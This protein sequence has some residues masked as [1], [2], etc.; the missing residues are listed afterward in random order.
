[1][2]DAVGNITR[3]AKQTTTIAWTPYGKVDKVT[4]DD[5]AF[6]KFLY[7]A[8]GNR[9]I[10]KRVNTAGLETISYYVRDPSG[11]I[12]AVYERVNSTGVTGEA[13]L[14][15]IPIY[16]SQRLGAYRK[17]VPLGA[18]GASNGLFNRELSVRQYELNDHLGNVRN[19]VS[20]RKLST[21]SGTT[22]SNF[23]PEVV[24][25]SQLLSVWYGSPWTYL[26]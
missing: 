24:T 21:L 4:K 10:K 25:V 19:V 3:D 5:A 11:N 20:D 13:V 7:D 22:F 23:E 15:E 1:L 26:E 9:I 18:L 16:G 17:A 6:T 14:N 2:Y 8:S 12:M